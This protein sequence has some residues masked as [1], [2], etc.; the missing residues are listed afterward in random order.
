MNRTG[1]SRVSA[2]THT[3]ASGPLG[4]VTTPPISSLSIATAAAGACC[5]LTGTAVS[6]VKAAI[7]ADTK[8]P[9]LMLFIR[10]V[11][12][13]LVLSNHSPLHV[14][15]RKDYACRLRVRNNKGGVI[16]SGEQ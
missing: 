16:R 1:K 4:P 6:A 7:A 15:L 3:P 12:R 13:S 10:M 11:H 8:R 14:G 2:I 9:R 5:A